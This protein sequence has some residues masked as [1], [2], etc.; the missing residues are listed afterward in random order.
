[1]RRLYCARKPASQRLFRKASTEDRKPA[2]CGHSFAEHAKATPIGSRP[3]A[4]HV[5]QATHDALAIGPQAVVGV[6]VGNPGSQPTDA[7]GRLL[8]K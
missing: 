6:L 4:D 1:M 8:G 5:E 3:A 7:T 2:L